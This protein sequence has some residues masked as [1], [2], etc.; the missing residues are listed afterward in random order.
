MPADPQATLDARHYRVPAIARDGSSVWI[1]A[2]RPDDHDRLLAHFNALSPQ[3]K[4]FRFHGMKRSLSEDELTRL[5]QVDFVRHVALV[6]TFAETTEAPIVGVGRYIVN[7]GHPDRAEIGCA[8]LDEGCRLAA[9]APYRADCARSGDQGVSGRSDGRE[10]SH[11]RRF[12]RQ[13]FAD[14]RAR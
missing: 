10:P 4:I 13:R 6:L 12:C 9:F 8:V 11:D 2:I 1:R 14:R 5:T 3:S 7:D